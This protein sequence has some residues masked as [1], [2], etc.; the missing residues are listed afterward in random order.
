[1][2]DGRRWADLGEGERRRTV[3]AH[4][5]AYLSDEEVN[6]C[7]G[8]GTVLANE[9]VTDQGRSERGDFPVFRRTLRQWTL[10]ITAYADRLDRDLSLVDW[11]EA[12]KTQQRRWI[13]GMRDWLF[14]RQRYWGEPFPI[15]YDEHGPIAL[16]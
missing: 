15:V 8:L 16:P 1:T 2:P 9:E 11:P 3:D 14:S 6:W 12:I 5:L 13:P 4:R 7:P 10:R